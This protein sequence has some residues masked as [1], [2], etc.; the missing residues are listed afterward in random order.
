MVTHAPPAVADPGPRSRKAISESY[1]VTPST[2]ALMFSFRLNAAMFAIKPPRNPH[3]VVSRIVRVARGRSFEAFVSTAFSPGTAPAG[4]PFAGAASG[5]SQ[6]RARSIVTRFQ[7]G[8]A[9]A[10]STW[11]PSPENV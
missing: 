6:I 9:R 4:K 1:T 10:G 11:N 2:V 3:A 8:A 5:A 7:P